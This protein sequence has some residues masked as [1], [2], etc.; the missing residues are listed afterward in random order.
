[1]NKLIAAKG[2][3]GSQGKNGSTGG[4]P[5]FLGGRTGMPGGAP[6]KRVVNPRGMRKK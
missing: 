4:R 3:K 2:V 6:A 5:G 1:M